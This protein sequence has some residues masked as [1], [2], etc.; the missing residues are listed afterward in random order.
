[1]RPNANKELSHRGLA[2]RFQEMPREYHKGEREEARGYSRTVV[3]RSG[4]TL[5]LAGVTA[6]ED[7]DGNS[8]AGDFEAQARAVF[9]KMEKRLEE[10]GGTL[11]DLVTMTVFILDVRHGPKF[12]EIRSGYFSGGYPASAQITVAGFAHPDMMIE[13]QAVAVTGDE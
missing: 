12:G 5:W 13:I 7:E 2:G 9:R 8:L 1:M 11:Q 10:A 3:T 6:R 4:K